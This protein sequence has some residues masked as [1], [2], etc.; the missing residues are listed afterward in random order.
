MKQV[1]LII[2]STFKDAVYFN[3][4]DDYS[5]ITRVLVEDHSPWEEVDDMKFNALEEFVRNYNYNKKNKNKSFAFIIEKPKQ[6]PAQQAIDEI[7]RIRNE[8]LEM[9]RIAREK[10]EK[11]RERKRRELEM[12]KLAK[13]KE[14]KRKLLEQLKKELGE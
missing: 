7:L 6:I 8:R 5:D 14:D 3:Y 9:D 13:S 2:A 10:A 4:G 1:K 11:E 12:K